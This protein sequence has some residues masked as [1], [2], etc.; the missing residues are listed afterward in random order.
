MSDGISYQLL[1]HTQQ[2]SS[3]NTTTIRVLL[4]PSISHSVKVMNKAKRKVE[5]LSATTSFGSLESIKTALKELDH[6]LGN[7]GYIEPGHRLKGKQK[8]LLDD[9][10]VSQMYV[11]HKNKCE[12]MLYVFV[13]RQVEGGNPLLKSLAK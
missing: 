13:D 9:S 7:I 3:E 4:T 12:V 11:V 6:I 2:C 1:M 5:K 8:W 10:V